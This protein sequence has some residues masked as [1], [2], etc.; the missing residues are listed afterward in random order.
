MGTPYCRKRASEEVPAVIILCG[1]NSEEREVSITSGKNVYKSLKNE[2]VKSELFV[3]DGK[4]KSLERINSPCFIALHGSPG[5]DGSVQKYFDE[6]GIKYT[7]A[8]CKSCEIT[9]DKIKTKK[10]FTKMGIKTPRWW[11][12]RPN[13]FPYIAK[14]R[15]GGSSIGTKLCFYEN[16]CELSNDYFYEEYINGREISV[17]IVELNGNITILPILEIL[18]SGDFYDYDSKYK[19]DGAKLIAPAALTKK[20]Q[21][22]INKSAL[23][24]YKN[25]GLR[26]FA[27]IDGIISKSEIYFLE[28]NSIPGMTP[29]SDLPASAKAAGLSLGKIVLQAVK[30]ACRR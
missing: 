12:E 2:G 4:F 9:Y 6:R 20:E 13:H 25:M 27:R 16:G 3:W 17:S 18:P 29:T 1:G 26:D 10:L 5:E 28:V 21:E 22:Q 19:P 11:Y 24:I 15:F 30:S 7:G 8:G 14:S 23:K